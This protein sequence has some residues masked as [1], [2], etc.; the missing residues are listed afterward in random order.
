MMNKK[1]RETEKEEQDDKGKEKTS[2][3]KLEV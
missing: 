2:R 1:N 3:A